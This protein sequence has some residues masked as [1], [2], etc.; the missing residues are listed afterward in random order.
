M[1]FLAFLFQSLAL[2][3]FLIYIALLWQLTYNLVLST[4]HRVDL[5]Q[6]CL[7][8]QAFSDLPSM[9]LLHLLGLSDAVS[10]S[11]KLLLV[12]HFLLPILRIHF[13]VLG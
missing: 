6:L 8:L 9:V 12:V 4:L 3:E 10:H 7:Q 13:L 5:L 2:V 1:S 11:L